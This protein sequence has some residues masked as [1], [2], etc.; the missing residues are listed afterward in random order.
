[1][2]REDLIHLPNWLALIA[3]LLFLVKLRCFH[4]MRSERG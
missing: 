4:V 1:M 3:I 2:R